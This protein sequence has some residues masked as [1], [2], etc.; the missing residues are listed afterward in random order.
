VLFASVWGMRIGVHNGLPG[1]CSGNSIGI[2]VVFGFN[3]S[4][5][6]IIRSGSC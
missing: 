1:L 3:I 6:L 4:T 2:R 5:R